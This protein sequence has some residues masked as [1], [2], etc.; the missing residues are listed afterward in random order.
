[1]WK[2]IGIILILSE[3]LQPIDVTLE[4]WI[5]MVDE[6]SSILVMIQVCLR[7]GCGNSD[8]PLIV[9][10]CVRLD[11]FGI[12]G[13]YVEAQGIGSVIVPIAGMCP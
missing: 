8:K 9:G 13:L 3:F 11:S 4:L 5:W 12:T 6:S 7:N 2:H 10:L 1:M